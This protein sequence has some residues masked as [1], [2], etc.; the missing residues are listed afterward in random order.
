MDSPESIVCP[1]CHVP[2][3]PGAY[4]CG[5]CGHPL[6]K[7]P[8][9]ISIGKQIQ[10]YLVSFL[11]PP[12]GLVY[13]WQYLREESDKSKII[14]M[15]AV[16]LTILSIVIAWDIIKPIWDSLNQNLNAFNGIY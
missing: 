9:S 10:I 3:P 5:N 2:S 4:F 15:V 1:F 14:G 11:A 8:L 6:R 12:F 13:A 16:A 7:A